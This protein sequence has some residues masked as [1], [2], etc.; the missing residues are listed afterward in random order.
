MKHINF[1]TLLA[2]YIFLLLQP[3]FIW[4]NT[5]I[6]IPLMLILL[7]YKMIFFI[8][9]KIEIF[10]ISTLLFIFTAI[11]YYLLNASYGWI[12]LVSLSIFLLSLLKKRELLETYAKFKIIFV[13][14]II[15][16][17]V[18]WIMHITGYNIMNISLGIV[19]DSD[20]PNQ[21]KVLA[22]MHYI[23]LPGAVILNYMLPWSI[24]RNQGIFD[25]PGF[26]GTMSALILAADGYRLN[27][28]IKNIIIFIAGIS[29]LSFAFFVLSVFYILLKKKKFIIPLF[30]LFIVIYIILAHNYIRINPIVKAYTVN[31]IEM[32]INGNKN[33]DNRAI[34]LKGNWK[35]WKN[36]DISGILFG[37]GQTEEGASWESI[38]IRS[39]LVGAILLTVIYLVFLLKTKPE[40]IKYLDY[41]FILTFML[42]VYQ[43]QDIL[44]LYMLLIFIFGVNKLNRKESTY[45]KISS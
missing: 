19:K 14:A 9:I 25:E 8:P 18:Y 39:G 15:P 4:G 41:I 3:Y 28:N 1:S 7:I 34:N 16:S 23:K 38:F 26:L 13:I 2:L 27:K 11:Y 22:G 10:M 37:I 17:I 31:R 33:G 29:S 43:R 12:V 21:L 24:Y 6:L 40:N 42:S 36:A 30:L 45:D 20:V 5:W 32:V 44:N 35:N